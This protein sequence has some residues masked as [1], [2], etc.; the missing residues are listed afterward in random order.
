[1]NRFILTIQASVDLTVGS[2]P[3]LEI[4]VD[5]AV[6]SSATITAQTGVGS[7]LLVFTLDYTGNFPASLAFRFNGGSG[8]GD[9]TITIE[10]V[11]INGQALSAGDLTGTLLAQSAS[12]SVISTAAHDHLFGRVEPTQVDLGVPTQTGTAAGESIDG[13]SGQDI[14]DGA[15]GD[16]RIRGI[17]SD[18]AINGNAGNDIIFGESGND[19]IIGGAGNDRIW[20]N[21][22]D[23]LLYGQADNDFMFG[24]TG[25]DVL[26]GGL[27]ND[28]LIGETGD[29]ILYG[30]AGAD[31]LIGTSGDNTLNGDAGNDR[32]LGGT[33]DDTLYGGDDDDQLHGKN[34]NDTL[35]GDAGNDFITGGDGSDAIDG[36]IGNDSVFGGNGND[37]I[38]GGDDD[39]QLFGGDGLDTLNGDAG[40]D[41]LVGGAGADT[42]TGGV[43][44]DLL[45]G[46]GLDVFATST[47]LSG[48]PNVVFNKA[49][50]SFYQLVSGAVTANSAFDAAETT[51]LNGVNGHLVTINSAAENTFVQ[52]LAA[53]NEIWLGTTDSGVEGEWRWEGGIET[54]LQFWSGAAAGTAV[55]GLYNNWNGGEPNDFGTGEDHAAMR[56]DGFWNDL[57][58][59]NTRFYVI[60]WDASQYSDDNAADNLSG[61][62]NDDL[63]YGHGGNDI[64]NGDAGQDALFGG[65]GNDTVN[66]GSDND[67]IFGGAGND[68]LN[69]DAGND[70]IYAT[71]IWFDN[72]WSHRQSITV[73]SS[74]TNNDLTDFTVL[75]DGAGFGADF[76]GNVKADGSDIVI[77]SGDGTTVLDREVVSIDT[78]GQTME[79]HV[80]VPLVSANV[81]TDLNIYY[82][83]AAANLA[84]DATTWRAE[85]NGVWHMEDSLGGGGATVI[86]SSQSGINGQAL[87]GF[88]AAD[89]IAGQTGQGFQFNNNEYIAINKS[90]TG[91]GALPTVSASAWVNT[92]VGGGGTNDNWAILDFDRSEFF[93][94]YVDGSTG[95]LAFS[96]NV[97][98]TIHDMPAGPAVNDG[99]WHH[100]AAVY[101]GTDKILYVDGAEVARAVNAH[102]GAALGENIT[103][104]GFI[105][106]GS[107]ATTFDGT[108]NNLRYDGQLDDLRL[109]EGT[110][111]ADQIA[112][113]YNNHLNPST[114]VT[115]S[116]AVETNLAG[117]DTDILNGG[118]G[119]DILYASGGNDTLNGDAGN[120]TLYA[121]SSGNDTLNGGDNNDTLYGAEGNNILH[122]NNGD[123][124]IYADNGPVVITAGGNPLADVIL[125]DNPDAYWQLNEIA[126]IAA[127][128]Q[129]SGGASIDG[130]FQNGVVLGQTALYAGGGPSV[131]FDGINDYISVPDSVLINTAAVTERTIELVFNAD[132]TAGRQVLFEEGGGTNALTIYIDSGQ[133]YFNARDSG[134]WGP[135]TINTAI[136]A[137]QTYHAAIVL[138][139][140]TDNQLHGYLDGAL[141]G[142]GATATDLDSHS[143]DIGIGAQA[144]ANYYH[145]GADNSALIN[146]FQGRISDVALYNT[147]LL[148]TDIQERVDAIN[149]ILPGPPPAI[150]DTVY[151][152]DGFDQLYGGTGRDSFVFESASAFND[153]DEINDFN[154]AEYDALDIKDLLT[155]FVSGV[156]DIDDFVQI[157]TV[158]S[159]SIVAVD[160]NG[161]VGGSAYL[162]MAQIN[163]LAGLDPASMETNGQ[164][165]VS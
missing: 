62:N 89:E 67:V 120:D 132:T 3:L 141:V 146:F 8:D 2:D 44:N 22:G 72:D 5:A 77:T 80:R 111:S 88:T 112:A 82:G 139:T 137:G 121:S 41:A 17:G 163:G 78:V 145:D 23:D 52:T 87:S 136:N 25:N 83:N 95:Q 51:Q 18:D 4:L 130:T 31:T 99:T 165:I 147:A 114:H 46:H 45:H 86:D 118:L 144:N 96:T 117:S 70:T 61:N 107:E 133:I 129:G 105:G 28:I 37:N 134:E 49:T 125:T 150:D 6:V 30:G 100:V 12:Q 32:L 98:S 26:N 59:S 84:N 115:V 19:I 162:N 74:L 48:N 127:D 85:Y 94:F 13:T 14:I 39:D 148:Q 73:E 54:G 131:Q 119:D 9:E 10:S 57:E 50:N 16:D 29:D 151:G 108:K 135:F 110:L 64:I 38:S 138:D 153:V 109:Y 56:V 65:D 103:R 122:G 93:N 79:L 158:G 97:G 102:G 33:G 155:G 35:N 101:D 75:V 157:T 124:I 123:D 81:D 164:L 92:S 40:N 27:G 161:L 152:D 113:E 24:G 106:D 43:G 160:S 71:N 143:G 63:I 116:S 34:G 42:L 15:G 1:M 104:F 58:G 47:I 154:L 140:I 76:W 21:E 69:G 68:T 55:N 53:G 156:S 60:E 7:D 66:G 90:F 128:N 91:A 149:G 142:S 11:H 126:G 36:G 159:D 20:G